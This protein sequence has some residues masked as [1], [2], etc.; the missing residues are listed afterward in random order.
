MRKILFLFLMMIVSVNAQRAVQSI[1]LL[2]SSPEENYRMPK[3]SPDGNYAAFTG[4]N[5]NGIYVMGFDG[6]GLIKISGE[7]AAGWNMQWSPS[8]DKIATR[9]NFWSDD[10]RERTSSVIIYHLNGAEENVSGI[11]TDLGM[12]FWSSKGNSLHWIGEDKSF[13]SHKISEEADEIYFHR[14]NKLVVNKNGAES[15]HS[16]VEGEILFTGYSP[17]FSKAAVSYTGKGIF[18]F[19]FSTGEVFDFGMGEYPSWINNE[20][21]VVMDL[22]DD[23]HQITSSD[24]LLYNYDGTLIS[25]LTQNFDKPALYPSANKEGKIIFNTLDGEIYKMI[26]E[27]E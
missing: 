8:S 11:Q 25:N 24:I 5:N 2:A 16:P 15:I 17:D 10:K 9:V 18:V 21:L 22:K 26:V 23:G 4:N 13:N 1:E 6:S 19:N 7:S 3:I 20:K 14:D 27:I 12:P